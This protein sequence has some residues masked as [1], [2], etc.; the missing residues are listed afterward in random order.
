MIAPGRL[1]DLV[2]LQGDPLRD[3]QNLSRIDRVVKD[4]MVFDPA[5][6]M[7]SIRADATRAAR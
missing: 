6:L 5:E 4:G 1:S 3:L 7:R 2:I